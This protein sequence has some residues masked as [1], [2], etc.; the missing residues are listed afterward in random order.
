MGA[1]KS[2]LV[3]GFKMELEAPGCTPGASWWGVKVFFNND[4]SDVMPYL[5]AKLDST[6]YNHSAKIL[7]WDSGE[8]VR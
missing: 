8:G 4:I 5:N 7:I 1:E 6:D 2:R 3:N